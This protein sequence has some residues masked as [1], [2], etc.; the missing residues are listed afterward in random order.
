MFRFL[1]LLTIPLAT[2]AEVNT[3]P[4]S[5]NPISATQME[6]KLEPV[7]DFDRENPQTKGVIVYFHHWPNEKETE[8]LLKKTTKFGLKKTREIKMFKALVFEWPQWKKGEEALEVCKGLSDLSFL[9]YCEPEY[10]TGPATGYIRKKIEKKAHK[11]MQKTQGPTTEP[12]GDLTLSPE[13]TIPSDQSGDVRSCKIFS[14]NAG[15]F[16]GELSD[17]WAQELIGSDLLKKELKNA[18]PV[19]KNLVA[20]FDTPYSNRHDMGVKNLISDEGKHAVLP[21]IGNSMTNF[22][23]ALSSYYL[24]HSRRLLGTAN[25]KCKASSLPNNNSGNSGSV[26]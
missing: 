20:V 16:Q 23:V 8:L 1:L 6:K 22:N 2:G 11:K 25:K 9:E 14:A 5:S 12:K 19:K 17:Y 3:L 13:E 15:L 21:E 26:Q 18:P 4:S 24:D 7:P 10:F